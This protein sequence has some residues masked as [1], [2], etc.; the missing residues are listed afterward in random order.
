M[1][2]YIIKNNYDYHYFKEKTTIEKILDLI[3]SD[4]SIKWL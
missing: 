1:N 3:K 2:Q 4:K